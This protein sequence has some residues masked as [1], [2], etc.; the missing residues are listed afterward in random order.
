MNTM[1]VIDT[2]TGHDH[3][4]MGWGNNR[5][6]P[7]LCCSLVHSTG[8]MMR[9]FLFITISIVYSTL[10]CFT[11]GDTAM[12]LTKWLVVQF[13]ILLTFFLLKFIL[14]ELEFYLFINE[15]YLPYVKIFT[16]I[17]YRAL[18]HIWCAFFVFVVLLWFITAISKPREV[19]H[20]ADTAI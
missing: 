18:H 7:C 2:I 16:C 1:Y 4:T 17:L 9:L 10:N 14:L 3:N 15:Y 11:S 13:F 8:V 12:L 19:A 20:S 6:S 5:L